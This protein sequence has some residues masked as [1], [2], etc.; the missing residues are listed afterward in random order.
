MWLRRLELLSG[1]FGGALG[2]AALGIALYAPT[3]ELCTN[4]PGPEI[5]GGCYSVSLVQAQGLAS[6]SLAIALFGGFSLGIAV[7]SV[8][9]TFFRH[10]VLLILLWTCTV[11]LGAVTLLALLSIGIYFMPADALAL[12]ASIVGT[13]AA[14]QRVPA[15]A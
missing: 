11:L 10:R 9:H 14:L 7:F 3:D 12:L 2:L 1:V 6:L 5:R 8:S 15:R 4:T 13:V